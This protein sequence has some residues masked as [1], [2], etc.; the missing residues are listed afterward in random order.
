M[1]QPTRKPGRV[2][3]TRAFVIGFA[4][5]E[6]IVIAWF[7]ASDLRGRAARRAAAEDSRTPA[8]RSTNP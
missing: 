8:T 4:I 5:V 6:A 1:H 7:I 3:S 2:L